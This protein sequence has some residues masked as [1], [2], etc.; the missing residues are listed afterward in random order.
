M[1]LQG[2][3]CKVQVHY[4]GAGEVGPGA[5]SPLSPGACRC[6]W[7]WLQGRRMHVQKVHAF[8]RQ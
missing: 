6:C 7:C 3:A 4:A 2:S 1:G 5:G 8:S